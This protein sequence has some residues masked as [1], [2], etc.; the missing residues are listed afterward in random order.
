M[1][2]GSGFLSLAIS[3][4]LAPVTSRAKPINSPALRRK[5]HR[6]AVRVTITVPVMLLYISGRRPTLALA[7]AAG[8][9]WQ[10]AII[11]LASVS[12]QKEVK[13]G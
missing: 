11:Y 9:S 2:L 10:G 5:F 1:V 12:R 3:A 7:G 13:P 4:W 6:V 8:L